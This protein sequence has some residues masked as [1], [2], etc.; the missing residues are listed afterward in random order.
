V[1]RNHD[2]LIAAVDR[3]GSGRRAVK[4]DAPPPVAIE[5]AQNKLTRSRL[6]HLVNYDFRH[7]VE[8]IAVTLPGS[9]PSEVVIESPDSSERQ[10]LR[11]TARK[12]EMT[13]RVP[14][15]ATYTLVTITP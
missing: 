6:L 4:V 12:G 14:R 7:P 3:A 5:L 1:P 13:F 15:L 10:T 9:G 8:G 2:E 11:V